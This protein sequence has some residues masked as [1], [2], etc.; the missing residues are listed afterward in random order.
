MPEHIDGGHNRVLLSDLWAEELP[1][2]SS[3]FGAIGVPYSPKGTTQTQ[4]TSS[5][6]RRSE[7]LFVTPREAAEDAL[8]ISS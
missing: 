7:V 6:Q 3:C 1:D 2:D 5:T 4:R 8:V